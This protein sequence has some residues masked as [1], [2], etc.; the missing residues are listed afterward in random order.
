VLSGE[1][2]RSLIQANLSRASFD[3]LH[4]SDLQVSAGRKT[5]RGKAEFRVYAKGTLQTPLATY[6]MGTANSTWS[7]GFQESAPGVWKVNRITPMSLPQ[8]T[9][10][11]PRGGSEPGKGVPDLGIGT[12]R[13]RRFRIMPAPTV[14]A[15]DPKP[16]EAGKE[17][18]PR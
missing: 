8:G 2:T 3:F 9:I 17:R 6:N 14:E 16:H 10:S 1:T 5:R 13:R 18:E 15:P 4:I 7:L 12:A 11:V